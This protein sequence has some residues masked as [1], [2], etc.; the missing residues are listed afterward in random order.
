MKLIW[1]PSAK[2]DLAR[3]YEFLSPK[4]AKAAGDR[5][6]ALLG[7]THS[8]LQF[9]QAGEQIEDY[10]PREVRQRHVAEYE[11][12]YEIKGDT[13]RVLRVWHQREDRPM[14]TY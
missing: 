6:I 5:V 3:V 2:R 14:L 12:R 1:S 9:P 11:V 7:I 13:I 10:L 4:N 8:M